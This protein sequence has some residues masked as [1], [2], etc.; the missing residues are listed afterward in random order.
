MRA[1]PTRLLSSMVYTKPWIENYHKV[2]WD[3]ASSLSRIKSW[4]T[5]A[6]RMRLPNTNK[7]IVK[8]MMADLTTSFY[9]QAEIHNLKQALQH[10]MLY[11]T[12]VQDRSEK[13]FKQLMRA[14]KPKSI[15]DGQLKPRD[16]ARALVV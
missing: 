9:N 3:G 16:I 15:L 4:R 14:P 6:R 12:T 1:Y 10:E 5:L 8:V 13:Q 2:D 7:T 11:T